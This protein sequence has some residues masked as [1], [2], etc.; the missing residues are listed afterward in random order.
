MRRGAAP[1]GAGGFVVVATAAVA[2]LA[3]SSAGPHAVLVAFRAGGPVRG[4]LRPLSV[5]LSLA[6]WPGYN[7]FVKATMDAAKRREGGPLWERR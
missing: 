2:L 1:P 6:R 4:S 7:G 5:S 3:R